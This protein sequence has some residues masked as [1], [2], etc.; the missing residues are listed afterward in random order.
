MKTPFGEYGRCSWITPLTVPC[1][2]YIYF[3]ED[4]RATLVDLPIY[5]GSIP[6]EHIDTFDQTLK[7]SLRRIVKEGIDM[8]RMAMVINRDE[9]QV[10]LLFRL[11]V[12]ASNTLMLLQLRS[13]LESAKGDTFSMSIINDFL[14][15][16]EDGS[17]IEPSLDEF[18]QM[19]A[20]REWSSQQWTDL[21]Q[22]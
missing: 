11:F 6:T 13:K 2:T 5:I 3:S 21:L 7:D 4:V 14:Y 19:E 1:S 15:G 16:P 9:R 17:E 8:S 10:A 18:S 22:K 12:T 20:L